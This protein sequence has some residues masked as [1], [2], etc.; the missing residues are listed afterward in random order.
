MKGN[1]PSEARQ[2]GRGPVKHEIPMFN[3][4]SYRRLTKDEESR[5]GDVAQAGGP[6][7]A[8]AR[9]TLAES[10]VPLTLHIT[11][12]A[13][14]RAQSS[15]RTFLFD[16]VV[17]D[18]SVALMQCV[19]QFNPGR[20]YRLSSYVSSG[21]RRILPR[22]LHQR[23]SE[24]QAQHD[25]FRDAPPL[26]DEDGGIVSVDNADELEHQRHLVAKWT[27]QLP[28]TTQQMLA[29]RTAGASYRTIADVFHVSPEAAS[30][31]IRGAIHKFKENSKSLELAQ[32]A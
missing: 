14:R 7:A 29:M 26:L 19:H 1:I 12:Q 21:V 22:M 23:M 32:A 8:D 18:A 25:M 2:F 27:A 10:C 20:G 13:F 31:R 3:W 17:S 30:M 15:G 16:D 24:E 4:G 6:D 5:L 28:K 11:R 9:K